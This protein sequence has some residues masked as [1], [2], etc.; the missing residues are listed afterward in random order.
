[1][2]V[3]RAHL[4]KV[5]SL[6]KQFAQQYTM[7][8]EFYKKCGPLAVYPAISYLN[9]TLTFLVEIPVFKDT[10]DERLK[11]LGRNGFAV[12]NGYSG[13]LPNP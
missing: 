9:K 6:P 4:K 11:A 10:T 8:E 12:I 2:Y 5:F 3:D 1:M 7:K 13:G